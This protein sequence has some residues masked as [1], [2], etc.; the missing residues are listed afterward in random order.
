[1]TS[2]DE[3][4][5]RF[6]CLLYESTIHEARIRKAG[7]SR[8]LFRDDSTDLFGFDLD[9]TWFVYFRRNG[10]T[11]EAK[12]L[13]LVQSYVKCRVALTAAKIA[14]SDSARERNFKD[15]K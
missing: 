7:G 6:E 10:P 3:L 4:E 13:T 14:R 15:N 12:A 5:R 8:S 11:S 1:M 2:H 9:V